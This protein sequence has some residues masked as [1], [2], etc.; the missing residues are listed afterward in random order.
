M[1]K[2][3][4]PYNANLF[5]PPPLLVRE[6]A[7]S[8]DELFASFRAAVK[9]VDIFGEMFV[10]DLVALQCDVLRGRRLKSAVIHVCQVEAIKKFLGR[11]LDHRPYLTDE[12][13]E[14]LLD[15]VRRGLPKTE[16]E[17]AKELAGAIDRFTERLHLSIARK[18]LRGE[19]K[20]VAVVNKLLAKLRTHVEAI[21]A[22][23]LTDKLDAIAQIDR[24]I[25]IA[26]SRRNA[27]LREIDR[28]RALLAQRLRRSI[29]EVEDAE[30]QVVETPL[31][32]GK[33]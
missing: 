1:S 26:E 27:M 2:S 15:E 17:A 33:H 3:R 12:V 25:E 16:E 13:T 8:Y 4:Y 23:E 32:K 7:A 19:P 14:G 22:E 20:A 9:P 31:R 10:A 6:D 21:T 18:Y 5:G 29:Q 24:L 28:R 11:N 30:Y